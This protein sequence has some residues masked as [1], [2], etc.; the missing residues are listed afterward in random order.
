[1][2][3][4]TFLASWV[5]GV[6]DIAAGEGDVVGEETFFEA[7]VVADDVTEETAFLGAWAGAGRSAVGIFLTFGVGDGDVEGVTGESFLATFEG[8]AEE[9][10]L[11]ACVGGGTFITAW[12]LTSANLSSILG[13]NTGGL[14]MVL[15][16]GSSF[17]SLLIDNGVGAEGTITDESDLEP[18]VTFL[19]FLPRRGFSITDIDVDPSSASDL[20]GFSELSL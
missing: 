8:A 19:D 12:S 4:G 13:T 5:G 7:L 1:M 6:D 18:E 11:T 20:S 17:F 3:G 14:R 15:E 9:T 10:L 2:V 16:A